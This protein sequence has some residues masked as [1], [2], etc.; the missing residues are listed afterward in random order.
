MNTTFLPLGTL[1]PI[2][3]VTVIVEGRCDACCTTCCAAAMLA[4]VLPPELLAPE[5]LP[6]LLDEP[7]P[8]ATT[9]TI[10]VAAA[11]PA[12]RRI[13]LRAGVKCNMTVVSSSWG[14][15]VVVGEGRQPVVGRSRCQA[16]R[17]RPP[18][19]AVARRWIPVTASDAIRTAPTN[20]SA[21]H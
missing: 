7:Q 11:T 1:L 20:M 3:V 12:A 18:L 10:K 4:L 2:G 16:D 15:L 9:A 6:E 5:L 13:R 21:A 8:T 14:V 17:R 19:P